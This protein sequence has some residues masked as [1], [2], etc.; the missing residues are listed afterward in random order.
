MTWQTNVVTQY[1]VKGGPGA[2]MFVERTVEK[3]TAVSGSIEVGAAAS[4]LS[5]ALGFSVQR[6]WSKADTSGTSYSVPQGR[7]G[8][9]ALMVPVYLGSAER[10]A[11]YADSLS[12]APYWHRQAWSYTVYRRDRAYYA[13]QY[14]TSS[15]GPWKLTA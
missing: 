15:Y 9:I 2:T 13:P 3:A 7:Y 11:C 1:A 6:S 12:Q 8:R 4:Y 14:A 5:G 10:W